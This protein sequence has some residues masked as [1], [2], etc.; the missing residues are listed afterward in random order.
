MALTYIL[1]FGLMF[2]DV[3]QGA[4]LILAGLAMWLLKRINLGRIIALCGLSSIGFGFFYGSIFGFED[5][6]H[7]F[8]P[9][10]NINT[11]LF[12]AVAIGIVMIVIV[13]VLNIA[14]GVRQR[15]LQKILLSPN[16]VAGL[17]LYLTAVVVV[18]GVMGAREAAI[19]TTPLVVLIAAMLLLLFSPSHWSSS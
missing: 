12:A 19:P 11:T 18:L 6:L 4:V 1:F 10:E 13:M 3:G 17:V 7:G 16:G 14:N 9:M 15:N 2:G 8:N 5:I